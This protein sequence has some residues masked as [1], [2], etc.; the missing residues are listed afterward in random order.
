MKSHKYWTIAMV[1]CM[2]MVIYSG[3]KLAGGHRPD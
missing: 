1:F 2:I 3:H